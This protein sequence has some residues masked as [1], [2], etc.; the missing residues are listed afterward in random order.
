MTRYLKSFLF[1]DLNVWI[2]L[3]YNKHVHYDFAHRWFTAL[4]EEAQ[5]YFCRFTQIGFLRLLT[6][7]AV[8]GDQVLSQAAAWKIYDDWLL[9]GGASYLEEPPSIEGMFRS[10]TETRNIAPK[11]WADSYLAAFASV[12]DL[13][14][15]TFDRGLEGKTDHLLI[16]R[17]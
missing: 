12:A 2:A 1:P 15:V 10:F 5:L 13:R 9:E 3:T 17:P 6:T 16:L 4:P 11:D 8:M 7:P 14:L